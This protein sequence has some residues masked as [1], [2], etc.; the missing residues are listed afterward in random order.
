MNDLLLLQMRKTA[1]ERANSVDKRLAEMAAAQLQIGEQVSGL[2]EV[3]VAE[4]REVVKKNAEATGQAF[5]ELQTAFGKQIGTLRA[6]VDSKLLADRKINPSDNA[7]PTLN[8]DDASGGDGYGF[9][10]SSF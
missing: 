8:D 6:A 2:Q 7:P 5:A 1:D 10:T 4:L 3:V 9:V